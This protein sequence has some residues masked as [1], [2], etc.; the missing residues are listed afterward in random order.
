MASSEP[1]LSPCV[2][3]GLPTPLACASCLETPV[4]SSSCNAQA[5]SACCAGAAAAA[6]DAAPAPALRAAQVE[7]KRPPLWWRL[8]SAIWRWPWKSGGGGGDADLPPGWAR[9]T[10]R[11]TGQPYYLHASGACVWQRPAD[12]G[13]PAPPAGADAGAL[14]AAQ[15]GLLPGWAAAWSSSRN[16][17]FWQHLDGRV[18]CDKPGRSA[19]AAAIAAALPA[20]RKGA[21]VAGA[22][23]ER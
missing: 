17:V 23:S 19:A 10:S 1:L 11:S 21:S 6:R 20:A 2:A 8:L 13:A 9:R 14:A 12:P 5:H 18:T 3:C 15:Q 4:C 16:D 22:P 7:P